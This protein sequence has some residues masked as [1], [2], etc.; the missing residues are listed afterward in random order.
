[1]EFELNEWL[2]YGERVA[3]Q[4]AKSFARIDEEDIYQEIALSLI[5]NEESLRRN[6]AGKEKAASYMK[7]VLQNIAYNY[8]LKENRKFIVQ[9]DFYEYQTSEVSIMI[10]Q[11]I[12]GVLDDILV[13]EEARS[14]RGDDN[15]AIYGDIR[16]AIDSLS[17]TDQETLSDYLLSS[18]TKDQAE[19]QRYSRVV[20][21]VTSTLNY[22]KTKA[23][24]EYQ[25]TGSRKAMTNLKAA[26]VTKNTNEMREVAV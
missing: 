8:C 22:N 25:G 21:K 5:T 17:E 7:K 9:S 20:K 14:V 16:R 15:L 26:A 12:A 23:S 1:M 19:R 3:K 2:E 13:P 11:V 18:D 4:F 6:L 10:E 24:K